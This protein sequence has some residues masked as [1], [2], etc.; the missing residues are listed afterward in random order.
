MIFG[1]LDAFL[2]DLLAEDAPPLAL[3]LRPQVLGGHVH[4]DVFVGT[5]ADHLQNAGRL[6]V[7]PKQAHVFGAVL[8]LGARAM[9]DKVTFLPWPFEVVR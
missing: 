1:D 3:K 9:P 4:I 5:D 2:A 7:G 8:A 6:V